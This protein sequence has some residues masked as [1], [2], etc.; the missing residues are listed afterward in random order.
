MTSAT[1]RDGNRNH[2]ERGSRCIWTPKLKYVFFFFLFF[3]YFSNNNYLQQID[4]KPLPP[5]YHCTT[6]WKEPKWWYKPS[7][8]P[9]CFFFKI[10]FFLANVIIFYI[11]FNNDILTT[12]HSATRSRRKGK[13]KGDEGRSLRSICILSSRSGNATISLQLVL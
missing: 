3:S 8:G 12:D 9:R 7:F 5:P 2:M 10:S 1:T 6:T 11:S 4:Y 13:E